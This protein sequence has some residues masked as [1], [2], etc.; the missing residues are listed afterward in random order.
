MSV[1]DVPRGKKVVGGTNFLISIKERDQQ[2]WKGSI[3]WLDTGRIINFRSTIEMM[4]LI[5]EA[6]NIQSGEGETS[7]SWTMENIVKVI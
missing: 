4:N 5:D 3:Q 1:D 2:N 7:R 6:I